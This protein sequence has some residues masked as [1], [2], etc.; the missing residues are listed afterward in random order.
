MRELTYYYPEPLWSSG[1]FIKNFL[2]FFDEVAL[3][4]PDYMRDRVVENDP[5]MTAG[6]VENGALEILEPETFIDAKAAKAMA[7]TLMEIIDSG[8]LDQLT[9]DNT[10]FAALSYSRLGVF[11]DTGVANEIL[12]EL[13]RRKLS[14]ATDDTW[15]IALHPTIRNL[16]LVM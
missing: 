11:A 5:A 4:V 16:I 6:L 14:K 12:K 15:S 10:K 1:D 2:L 13:K 3:L 9:N 8:K 7:A